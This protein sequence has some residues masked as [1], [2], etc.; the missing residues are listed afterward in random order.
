VLIG[1]LGETTGQRAFDMPIEDRR[2]PV[3]DGKMKTGVHGARLL[4][5]AG[6]AVTLAIGMLAAGQTAYAAG[7]TPVALGT[8]G[9]FAVLAGTGITNIGAT[10][11]TGDVGSYANPA[12]T[13]FETVTLNGNNH[14]GDAVT[15]GAKSALT[16]AYLDAAGRTPP[17]SGGTLS[18]QTLVGGIYKGG[19]LALTGTLTLD[20]QNDPSSVWVFQ[21]ASDLV[22]ASGSSVKLIN[23]ANSCNVFWQV[24]SSATLNSGST[25]VGTIMALTSITIKTGVTLNGRALARNGDVTLEADKIADTCLIAPGAPGAPAS[26]GASASAGAGA[27]ASAGAGAS[28]SA[29]AGGGVTPAPTSTVG[30]ISSTNSTLPLLPLLLIG[31][32]GTALA[33]FVAKQRRSIR[34]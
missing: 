14:A 8:A 34:S 22:T 27:S 19:A 10:T 33:I 2:E 21:A 28:A 23:G 24:T 5:S 12:E 6:T 30:D 13:G 4:L 15:Q 16:T 9:S 25:F 11:I 20:G 31:F 7:P 29:R 3:G 17:T 32:A 18:G 26:P 1:Y